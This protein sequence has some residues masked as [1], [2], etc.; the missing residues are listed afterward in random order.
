VPPLHLYATSD[1]VEDAWRAELDGRAAVELDRERA[2]LAALI[3]S[4]S[5]QA[6]AAPRLGPLGERLLV[7]A[8]AGAAEGPFAAIADTRG[9]RRGLGRA[10][11][12]VR[13]AG[14]S[15]DELRA[16]AR[17]VAG[18]A[19]ARAAELARRLDAYERLRGD[20][21]DE[22]EVGRRA[23]TAIAA[24]APVPMLADAD[25]V[26]VHGVDDWTAPRLALV[27]ALDARGLPV[28][29]HLPESRPELT[30]ALAPSLSALEARH[31]QALELQTFAVEPRARPRFVVATSPRGEA[32]AVARRVRDLLD[33][34]VAPER[35]AVCAETPERRARLR[36]A[37]ERYDV[38]V[39]DRRAAPAAAAPPVRLALE[40]G[41]AVDERLPRERL[42]A[43][44]S[45]RYVA[46]GVATESGWLPP[47]RVARALREAGATE[48]AAYHERLAAWARAQPPQQQEAAR[49]ICAHVD[50]W[51]T[52][53]VRLPERARF[54]EHAAALLE[55]LRAL[56]LPAR[57]RGFRASGTPTV[58]ESRA[59]AR[60]QAAVR[61]LEAA[62]VDLPRAAAR[63][64]LERERVERA[65]FGRL[66]GEVL[67]SRP[68]RAGGVRGGA[69]ELTDLAGAAGRAFEHLFACG[70]NDGELPPR[71]VEDALF[72]DDE[73]VQLN[74]ALGRAALPL[75]S[76]AEELAPLVFARAVAAA[77][78]AHLAWTR[79][80]EDGAPLLR[81]PLI[82][83]LR[84]ADDE[85]A[86]VGLE[87]IPSV[88]DARVAAELEARVALERSGDRASRLSAPDA[89]A[90]AALAAV[91]HARDPAR[92]ERVAQRIAVEHEREQ[93]FD[94][95]DGPPSRF[96][97]A[98]A[99]AAVIDALVQRLPGA[100][101]APLSASAL[102]QYSACPFQFF[103]RSVLRAAPVEELDDDLDPMSRGK[104]LHRV[105]ER[106]FRARHDAGHTRLTGAPD[107]QRALDAACDEVIAEWRQT[108]HVGHPGLFAV[109]ERK[110]RRQVA[111]LV[112]AETD[113]PPLDGGAPAR[114]EQRFGPLAVESPEG[115]ER[116]F[117]HGTIDRVDLAERRALVLDYKAGLSAS[118]REK[119]R[120]DAV[121]V[122]S[123]QL[124]IYAAA[125]QAELGAHTTVEARFYALRDLT[126]TRPVV[127]GPLL[128]LD[129]LGRA[130]ARASGE[131]NL[132]DA[133]WELYRAMR[134]GDF[135]V[136]P[137]KGACERC[138]LEAACRVVR[139]NLDEDEA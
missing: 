14:V 85:L 43:L 30:R 9:L 71:A 31:A 138:R 108:G 50:R 106:F 22:A 118:Y 68:L 57:A 125:M 120:G 34:G 80:D 17:R 94:R 119:V 97:G 92:L 62:L 123:W 32:R 36:E 27:D 12:D 116:L 20:R 88:A 101:D 135:A 87:P 46:G 38:P 3:E 111:A 41:F 74:R 126:L 63:A 81:S 60:D 19:A 99:D 61:E 115:G 128:A 102:E 75:A 131:R 23:L 66:L 55:V 136:R 49:A 83:A 117:L 47:H 89:A 40:L 133:L 91:L 8:V 103:V 51:V 130:R 28:R 127:S 24:R 121:C 52:A 42:I 35:V 139:R 109:H 25:A 48:A 114:F 26:E 1:A 64:G 18:P 29:V 82:A 105:L 13:R 59:V 96:A 37:L 112:R 54:A 65:R 77:A 10:I 53:L 132:G 79:A 11:A 104:L 95:A 2:T 100:E 124:P 56:E 134:A 58:D 45:S 7:D 16:A 15:A 67:A 93:F 4:A 98:L 78:Q 129:D 70:L 107:E 110:L 122:S 5:A 76:R 39:A 90:D 72:S 44:L 73:R 84:P 69:V 113:Q 6:G 21:L 86:H 33:G 137:R